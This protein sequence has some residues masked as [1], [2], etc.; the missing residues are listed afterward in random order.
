MNAQASGLNDSDLAKSSCA[1]WE[2]PSLPDIELFRAA[3]L[4]H[5]YPRH[6][7]EGYAIGVFEDGVGGTD[8]RGEVHYIP[9]GHVVAMNAGEAHTGFAAGDRFFARRHLPHFKDV[10]I[11]DRGWAARLRELHRQLESFCEL[12]DAETSAVETLRQFAAEF[13]GA[14]SDTTEGH[15]V[16][17]VAR[18]KEF[19]R[20]HHARNVSIRELA[21]ITDLSAGYLI[22]AFRRAT[23]L[24]PHVWLMQVR[25]CRAKAL[26]A[27]GWPIAEIALELGFADQS[28]FTRK[29]RSVTGLTPA[30]YAAGHGP[31]R[32]NAH[33]GPALTSS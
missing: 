27:E 32:R 26:I 28:H 20:A 12:L 1:S 17:A 4:T 14:S 21:A 22:R 23:G 15:E 30:R 24:P 3:S 29:F 11:D 6:S 25:V 8:Y 7:H 2:L 9:P 16:A 18:I 33:S 10:C 19:L 5:R 13:G 31:L